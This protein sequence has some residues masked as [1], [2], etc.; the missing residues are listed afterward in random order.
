MQQPVEI[1]LL[2][3]QVKL[4]SVARVFIVKVTLLE[5]MVLGLPM[6]HQKDQVR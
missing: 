6:H 1:Q 5:V 3:F 4:K 2:G